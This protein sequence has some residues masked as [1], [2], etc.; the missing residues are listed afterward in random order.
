[1]M[2]N[3]LQSWR[4]V[5]TPH[6]NIC[7][8]TYKN[9][10]FMAD[11]SK[12]SRG[13]GDSEYTDA[14]EFF[15]RTYLTAGLKNLL[16]RALKRVKDGRGEPVIQLKTAFGGGKT[17][18]MLALYHLMRGSSELESLP[19][20]RKV[21]DEAG[22]FSLPRVKVVV[23]G[24]TEIDPT[25]SVSVH[26]VSV[27][28]LWGNI[29]AQ[30]G[31]Y[32]Y[33]RRADIEGISPG[34]RVL[35]E[36]FDSCGPC[37]VLMDELVAYGRK[38]RDEEEKNIR[39]SLPAG[40]FENFLTFI[41]ELTE[42]AKFSR[43]SLV[44]A[45]LP[46]SDSEAGGEKGLKVLHT[47]EH[48]FGRLDSVWKP[49][50]AS[51]GFEIVRRRLF[52][53]CHDPEAR[54]KTAE[55]YY[56]MYQNNGADFPSSAQDVSYRDRIISCYP[57]HPE[58]FDRLYEDWATLE[59]FQRTRGVL[60]LMASVVRKLWTS[61]DNSPLIMPG[62]LPLYDSGVRYELTRALSESDA[63]YSIVDGDIDG[64]GSKACD[65]DKKER[66]APLSAARR[67]A[68]TIMLG[69]APSVRSQSLRGLDEAHIL[70]GTVQPG[71]NIAVYNDAVNKLRESLLY[72]YS[73]EYRLWFDTRATLRKTALNE[74][75]NITPSQIEAEIRKRLN[76]RG[77]KPFS[78]VHVYSAPEDVPDSEELRLVVLGSD[79]S[80]ELA[81][82]I[83]EGRKNQNMVVFLV[84]EDR[85]LSDVR[86][87]AAKYLAWRRL[88][89]KREDLNLDAKQNRELNS[90]VKSLN[91]GL[92]A[93]VRRA[94]VCVLVPYT[95]RDSL[96][97]TRWEK[98]KMRDT[99][100]VA[101]EVVRCLKSRDKLTEKWAASH[102]NR[103]LGSLVWDKREYIGVKTLWEYV[104]EYT[105]LPRLTDYGVLEAGIKE[106]VANEKCFA[107]AEGVED[108]KYIGLSIEEP[109]SVE[110][111][112]LLVRRDAAN[113][114]LE[115]E[116]PGEVIDEG[117]ELTPAPE[118]PVR[119]KPKL[120][121]RFHMNAKLSNTP[122]LKR[123]V[124]KII[125]D[126][127]VNLKGI[128][129]E[130]VKI[131]LDVIMEA[132]NGIDPNV[133]KDVSDNCKELKLDEN[134]YGFEE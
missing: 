54:D 104:C 89:T 58:L 56:R 66:F 30:L 95:E 115:A 75:K 14:R 65:I 22:V 98:L 102:M 51:E 60:R 10:E 25:S 125:D 121:T 17:H 11:L 41:Q 127:I 36:M 63:W 26:G 114:Q 47:V 6:P 105:Y 2:M 116:K 29:G 83:L 92:D 3:G 122:S 100:E 79:W 53:E 15:S 18:S 19:V 46:E 80:E 37:V 67:S 133:V 27:K 97:V 69:S 45:T 68:R 57:F 132:P 8:G 59:N 96:S 52:L 134:S 38:L 85:Q 55:A 44:V 71:E 103:E 5:I 110:K 128:D 28:T 131:S 93:A 78:H 81:L 107:L 31:Q 90:A 126:V 32:E 99:G 108:G 43:N 113:R 16:V 119:E 9:D 4:K 13:E 76:F 35:A 111:S 87:V 77:R 88:E 106:G 12:A 50:T 39:G 64:E 1:M 91:E 62:S 82:R 34:N 112:D 109:A 24:C 84:P 49:V 48:Y 117:P 123:D 23:L 74:Q 130:D 33:V 118:L 129:G 124:R 61:D 70:L 21:F 72:L 73:D 7:E 120:K 94:W 86:E 20:L 101:E 40:T 42:A